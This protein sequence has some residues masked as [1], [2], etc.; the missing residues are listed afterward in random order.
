[1]RKQKTIAQRSAEAEL[2]AEALEASHGKAM[3]SLMRDVGYVMDPTVVIDAKATEN[4]L[5]RL[6]V[7]RMKHIDVAHLWLQDE[8]RSRR[9]SVQRGTSWANVADIGTKVLSNAVI[10]KHSLALEYSNMDSE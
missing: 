2:Y 9:L 8:V 10:A 3:T 4:I 5:H 1:M 7:G 6:N